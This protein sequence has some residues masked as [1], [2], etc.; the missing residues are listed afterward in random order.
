MP[1]PTFY[2]EQSLAEYAHQELGEIARRLAWEVALGSYTEIIN[3]VLLGLEIAEPPLSSWT[4]VD[5]LQQLRVF[6]R[7]QTWKQAVK[8]LAS[9]YQFGADFQLFH[10]EQM[11]AMASKSLAFAEA[12][13][14]SLGL[15]VSGG[16]VWE[17]GVEPLD[18]PHDPYAYYPLELQS[19]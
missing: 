7:Y 11:Q 5:Q 3:E 2:T 15:P 9:Y 4:S 16:T 17:I 13:C 19:R 18:Y 8:N 6:T 1:P 12:E 14:Q 10:R